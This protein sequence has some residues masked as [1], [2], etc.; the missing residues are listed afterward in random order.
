MRVVGRRAITDWDR[1]HALLCVVGAKLQNRLAGKV[2]IVTGASRGLGLAISKVFA[3]EGATVA[4]FARSGDELLSA[5]E[6]APRALAIRCDVA[7]PEAVRRGFAQVRDRCGGLD[8][9]INNAALATPQLIE[10][11]EDSAARREVEVNILGP[12]YCM[13]EAIGMMRRRGGGDII[14]ISSE[15]VVSH[16]PYLSLYAATKWALEALTAG[17][18]TELRGS[19]IRVSTYRSGRIQSSFHH[20]WDPE[21][22]AK[23]RA[24]AADSGFVAAA[25]ASIDPEIPARAMLELVLLDRTA[26]VDLLHLRGA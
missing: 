21:V 23:V 25:G 19:N 10:E 4:M 16:Y 6:A 2:A 17:A 22:A 20:G 3:S 26:Q 5:A 24:A 14:N 8:V 9:L 12:L 1:R 15:S 18:R 7:D 11:V 13:R